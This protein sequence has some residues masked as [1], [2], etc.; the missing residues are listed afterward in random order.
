MRLLNKHHSAGR[1][2]PPRLEELESR[3]LLSVAATTYNAA[4]AVAVASGIVHSPEALDDF[5]V[6]EYAR[7]L[8]R[9][10]STAEVQNW[11]GQMEAGLD[12]AVVEAAFV[13]S[14]EFVLQHGDNAS[15]WLTGLYNDLLDRA[16]DVGGFDYWLTRL[17]AGESA[18][19]VALGFSTSPERDRDVVI[20]DYELYLN[21]T[22][23]SQGLNSWVGALEGGAGRIN[24][25][26][27]ILASQ[28]YFNR[29]GADA[30]TFV[31]GLY[32]DVLGRV[33]SP[34]EIASWVS[35]YEAQQGFPFLKPVMI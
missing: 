14:P 30:N 10:P 7:F 8:N 5:I 31:S 24:V 3:N 12:P 22:P 21:R 16:P 6:G 23:D 18:F 35:V 17:E 20:I 9:L 32:N 13:A 19:Q 2:V 34:S 33:A 15:A 29:H 27:G 28:E 1:S 11:V 4:S 25:L 26:A